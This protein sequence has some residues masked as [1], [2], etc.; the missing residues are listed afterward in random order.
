VTKGIVDETMLMTP[1]AHLQVEFSHR[2][3]DVEALTTDQ[4]ASLR[5]LDSLFASLQH[6]AFRGELARDEVSEVLA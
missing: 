3:A 2:V 5:D 4:R 1:L 6:R